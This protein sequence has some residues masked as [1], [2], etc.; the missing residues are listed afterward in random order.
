MVRLDFAYPQAMLAIEAH[1][2]AYHSN[3]LRW[4]HDHERRNFLTN[5]GWRLLEVT[6]DMVTNRA[7]EVVAAVRSAL[8]PLPGS[9]FPYTR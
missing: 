9:R 7:D 4:E 1:G 6:W 5:L 3:R 8:S 2:Y